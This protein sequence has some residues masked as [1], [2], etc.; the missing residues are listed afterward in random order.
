MHHSS[1]I[2]GINS[3]LNYILFHSM[4]SFTKYTFVGSFKYNVMSTYEIKFKFLL[5]SI[6]WQRHGALKGCQENSTGLDS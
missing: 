1:V 4:K 2:E 3:N 5:Q 6:Q